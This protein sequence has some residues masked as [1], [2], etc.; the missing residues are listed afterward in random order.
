MVCPGHHS[1]HVLRPQRQVNGHQVIAGQSFETSGEKGLEGD[2]AAVLLA[3]HDDQRSPVDPGADQGVDRIAEPRGG[4]QADQGGP[5]GRD[6]MAGGH[7]DGRV[8]V[9]GEQVLDAVGQVGQKR[10]LGRPWVAEPGCHA[11]VAGY[12][13]GR[14]PDRAHHVLLHPGFAA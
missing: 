2:V 14:I 6:G 4:V 12:L 8:L 3:D 7:A 5:A 1:R 10:D 11:E 9:Q 13:E